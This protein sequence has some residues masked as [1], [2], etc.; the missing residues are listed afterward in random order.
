MHL[1]TSLLCYCGDKGAMKLGAVNKH[2]VLSF[3]EHWKQRAGKRN[4][5]ALIKNYQNN[6]IIFIEIVKLH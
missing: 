3:G 5:Q 4:Q 1:K 2:Y 6:Y